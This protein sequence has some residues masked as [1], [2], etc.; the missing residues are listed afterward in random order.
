[1]FPMEAAIKKM[2]E[3]KAKPLTKT[4][5]LM[6]KSINNELKNLDYLDLMCDAISQS[7]ISRK[8]QSYII[9]C[10]GLS[11]IKYLINKTDFRKTTYKFDHKFS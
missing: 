1:M 2:P 7:K 6:I 9:E 3:H 10:G 8:F 11:L 5:P 4:S